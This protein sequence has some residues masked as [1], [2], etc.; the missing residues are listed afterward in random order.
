VGEDGYA[1]VRGIL[2][3]LV[4]ATGGSVLNNGVWAMVGGATG[5]LA[6]GLE[7]A[8]GA[9]AA[10]VGGGIIG[11]GLLAWL[12]LRTLVAPLRE[13]FEELGAQFERA[14][15]R[16]WQS[17]GDAASLEAAGRDFGE[18]VGFFL[19]LVLRGLVEFLDRSTGKG[20]Q[21]ADRALGVLRDS[22][23]FQSCRKLEPWLVENLPR[24]RARFERRPGQVA[25]P[26]EPGA[27]PGGRGG[28]RV[29][30]G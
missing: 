4:E 22:R 14:I 5:F 10:T 29:G 24:L 21:E 25:S 13:H 15:L 17:Q 20:G 27:Q 19:R 9:V 16:C 7:T 23:L 2:W 3:D 8:P 1:S 11:E 28:A 6:G 12:G 26:T 18:A 30:I